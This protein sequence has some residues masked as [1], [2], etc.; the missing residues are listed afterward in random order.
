VT[1]CSGALVPTG[2]FGPF[3]VLSDWA[4]AHYLG[5]AHELAVRKC[6]EALLVVQPAG[7]VQTTRYLRYIEG[8]A[9][10]EL[11]RHREAISVALD[12][13]ADLD[14]T[15]EPLWRAKGLALLAEASAG[16]GELARAMDALAEGTWL[17]QSAQP[18]S[19]SYLSASM[20]VALALRAVDLFEQAEELLAAVEG[21]QSLEIDLL[22]LNE[23][24]R[25]QAH[26][27]A[28]LELVGHRAEAAGRF[29]RCARHALRMRRLAMTLKK[30]EMAARAEVMA[31]YATCRLGDVG[32][33]AARV[34]HAR[35]GFEVHRVLTESHLVQLVLGAE[36]AEQ[37]AYDEARAM[38][39]S[40]AR[41]SRR[42]R[43]EVWAGTFL[44]ALAG[45]DVREHGPHPAVATWERLAREALQRTFRER[46]SRFRALQDRTRLRELSEESLR[47]G[48]DALADPL[49]GLG[50]RRLM[51][52]SL[53]EAAVELSVVFIDIDHFKEINDRFSHAV[54]DEVLLRL[55]AILR[56]HC[57]GEDVVIRYGGDEFVVLVIGDA[58]GEAAAGIAQ[59]LHEA[60]RV[61]DWDEVAQGLRVTISVG[62]ARSLAARTAL[63]AADDALY[64]AK[65]TGRD[66]V[67][68]A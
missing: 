20:A 46:E 7:D 2:E 48:R 35:E 21:A 55:A 66:Q 60:V 11:G 51:A 63:A 58:S 64:R 12:L 29:E 40:G 28:T 57:R 34:R 10:Q 53:A 13:V 23:L 16:V 61:T 54:G 41:Q 49:T 68:L 52:Q 42:L 1:G 30:P 59:R 8:I 27:G 47:A 25:L 44:Q 36:L 3:D 18:G 6:R 37:G 50:N 14:A 32:L 45:V 62:V 38:F 67:V 9:L 17:V 56:Q 22:V 19:Y 24:C 5:G 15:L 65:R 43:Q 26:W 31:A 39:A 33:A 4:H